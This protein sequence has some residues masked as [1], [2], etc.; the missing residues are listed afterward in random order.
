MIHIGWARVSWFALVCFTCHTR[1]A[2]AEPTPQTVA[3]EAWMGELPSVEVVRTK[4]TGSD[5]ED[6]AARRDATFEVLKQYVQARARFTPPESAPAGVAKSYHA[7][8]TASQPG[9]ALTPRAAAYVA[10]GTAFDLEVLTSLLPARS[11]AEYQATPQFQTK[12]A[13]ERLRAAQAQLT[14][15]REVLGVMLLD[16]LGLPACEPGLKL[17]P[18]LMGIGRG[19]ARACRAELAALPKRLRPSI[20]ATASP[21]QA[22]HD[23]QPIVLAD[24][25]C[26]RWMKDGGSCVFLV[27]IENGVVAGALVPTGLD[28]KPIESLLATKYKRPAVDG[29]DVQCGNRQTHEITSHTVERVWALDGLSVS[30]EPV[31]RDCSHGRVLIQT[32]LMQAPAP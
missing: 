1:T 29:D 26:P 10:R 20:L 4:V 3:G 23:W 17:P 28:A 27:A 30:F 22:K 32:A 16:P 14:A 31:S 12:K 11:V 18:D 25:T 19:A 13:A 6:S 5:A 2:L 7:Y 8:D 15:D 9:A 24:S 21:E